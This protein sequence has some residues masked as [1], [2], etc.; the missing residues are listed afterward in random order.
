MMKSK[1]PKSGRSTKPGATSKSKGMAHAHGKAKPKKVIKPRMTREAD[2]R[3]RAATTRRPGASTT[4]KS[5]TFILDAPS[6]QKVSIAGSFNNW[7]PQVMT[8]GRDGVWRITVQLVPG[9]HQYKFMVDAE[10]RDDPNN[11]R[12]IPNEYGGLNSICE[13]L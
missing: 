11:P 5:A 8:Q 6:S 9:A 1:T 7:E 12:K 10:W 4:K 13:V 2:E 3:I